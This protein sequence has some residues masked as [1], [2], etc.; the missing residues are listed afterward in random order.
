MK[1][2]ILKRE[3]RLPTFIPCEQP[4]LDEAEATLAASNNEKDAS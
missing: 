2:E 4:L 1:K 3:D